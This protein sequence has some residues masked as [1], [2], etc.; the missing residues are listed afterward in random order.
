MTYSN[1]N[2]SEQSTVNSSTNPI[3]SH[4]NKP[5]KDILIIDNTEEP[6]TFKND[7]TVQHM[8]MSIDVIEVSDETIEVDEFMQSDKQDN[9]KSVYNVNGKKLPLGVRDVDLIDIK[10]PNYSGYYASNIFDYLKSREVSIIM[11]NIIIIYIYIFNKLYT[12]SLYYII[13]RVK[14]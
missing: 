1:L 14:H 5:L 10:D 13:R 7:S 6:F 12:Y 11:H 9:N 3:V 4:P 8:D 2:S